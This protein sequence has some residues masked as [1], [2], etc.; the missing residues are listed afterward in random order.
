MANVS[1]L[2]ILLR[3]VNMASR[4]LNNLDRQVARA[5]TTAQ[6]ASSQ[7]AAAEKQ[8]QDARRNTAQVTAQSVSAI[9]GILSKSAKAREDALRQEG[10]L[11]RRLQDARGS[12]RVAEAKHA[13]T[14]QTA[15][16]QSAK[17]AAAI[18]AADEAVARSKRRVTALTDEYKTASI[19]TSQTIINN[20]RQ[21]EQTV[22][23]ASRNIQQ[24]KQNQTRV[25]Q[26]LANTQKQSAVSMI[27][28]NTLVRT[29]ILAVA[30]AA[31][32]TIAVVGKLG[33]TYNSM[34]QT[35]QTAFTGILKDAPKAAQFTEELYEWTRQTSLGFDLA[36]RSAQEFLARGF[37]VER[38]IPTLE[39]IA[40]AAAALPRP[41]EESMARISYAIGQISQSAKLHSQDIR[42]LTEAGINAWGY[43]QEAT[44][45]SIDEMQAD[46]LKFGLTGQHVADIILKGIARDFPNQ[47]QLQRSTMRGATAEFSRNAQEIAGVFTKPIFDK[48][49][50]GLHAVNKTLNDPETRAAAEKW[51]EILSTIFIEPVALIVKFGGA[52]IDLKNILESLPEQIGIKVK[53]DIIGMLPGIG[54]L[55]QL[56]G[57]VEG[58]YDARNPTNERRL[59]NLGGEMQRLTEERE[60]ISGPLAQRSEFNQEKLRALD[61]EIEAVNQEISS[62]QSEING[63]GNAANSTG[64]DLNSL[65]ARFSHANAELKSITDNAASTRQAAADLFSQPTRELLEAQYEALR[66]QSSMAGEVQRLEAGLSSLDRQARAAADAN[67][68]QVRA[69]DANIRSIERGIAARDRAEQRADMIADAVV[70][71]SQKQ[72]QALEMQERALQKQEL[73]KRA[74]EAETP[75]ERAAAQLA[76]KRFNIED[77]IRVEEEQAAAARQKLELERFDRATREMQQ[78]QQ[79]QDQRDALIQR[80]ADEQAA[81][82]AQKET[83]QAELDLIA[84][85]TRLK[86]GEAEKLTVA[87]ELLQKEIELMDP[88]LLTQDELGKKA[89]LVKDE[90][91]LLVEPLA[92]V[93]EIL[94][95]LALEQLAAKQAEL[96]NIAAGEAQAANEAYGGARAAGGRVYPNKWYMV[97]EHGPEPFVPDSAGT[98]L[99]NRGGNT[100]NNRKT[101]NLAPIVIYNGGGSG[102]NED[103]L[104]FLFKK[105]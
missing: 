45:A 42:Q 31:V 4:E 77:K 37:D 22:S 85:T 27:A 52:L 23:S 24:A 55:K 21:V 11:L 36:T 69:L 66:Y 6:R 100:T 39:S 104:D 81:F 57:V 25:E 34:K 15:D 92:A 7:I 20:E 50:E 51:G 80:G 90:F 63:L 79:L 59:G 99:P 32:G 43:L 53:V 67:A 26:S 88:F 91:A 103:A 33:F 17:G 60:R 47:L 44:G 30:A 73:R 64:A 56:A 65:T 48:F 83:I 98:I 105:M 49:L 95:T 46:A 89:A 9:E 54:P 70:S 86:Q 72:L 96:D 93:R 94:E 40:N 19:R 78:M 18:V 71:A 14:K 87:N 61:A 28:S 58:I 62:L 13:V 68:R 75:E 97:G 1:E 29:G 8:V 2:V 10:N 102:S 76:L 12:L 5:Q 82:D 74:R 35:A 38:V 3:A 16:A 101:V 84:E 41:M